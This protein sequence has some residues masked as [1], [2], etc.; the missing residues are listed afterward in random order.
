MNIQLAKGTRSFN[1]YFGS[2]IISIYLLSYS[3]IRCIYTYS[4]AQQRYNSLWNLKT[5]W[6]Q[7]IE[8]APA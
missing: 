5:Q 8:F 3:T 4:D 6:Y 2:I 7:W 1:P